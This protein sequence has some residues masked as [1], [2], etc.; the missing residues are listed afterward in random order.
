MWGMNGDRQTVNG[1]AGGILMRKK[2]KVDEERES[3]PYNWD[4]RVSSPTPL[5]FTLIFKKLNMKTFTESN[6]CYFLTMSLPHA[7]HLS[8]NKPEGQKKTD[9]V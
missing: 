1:T 9:V 2:D 8:E 7:V 3:S 4:R 6:G 5:P